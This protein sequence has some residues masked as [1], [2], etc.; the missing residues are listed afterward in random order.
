[1][2]ISF[3]GILHE[4]PQ[5][6]TVYLSKMPHTVFFTFLLLWQSFFDTIAGKHKSA[7]EAAA[8]RRTHMISIPYGN[9]H[10]KMDETGVVQILESRI[11]E[12]KGEKT[13]EEL[14]K[15][16]MEHPLG[17]PPLWELSRGKATAV[18]IISDHTRP[19]PSKKIIPFMLEQLRQGNPDIEITLLVATGCHRG[20]RREELIQKLGR[21]IVDGERI[22][23]HDC[24]DKEQLT[25]LGALPSG[26]RLVINRAAAETEL[27]VAE[28][29]IEPHFFA[30]FSGGRK[31]VLPGICSRMT[32]LGNHCAA[33]IDSPYA[34]T[35]N[36]EKNPIHRDMLAAAALAKLSYI[37][38]VVIDEDKKA[39]A[40][41]AGDPVQAHEAGC[42]FL[43]PYCQVRIQKKT[44]IV[45]TSN[46]G[47]PLD[48]NIY[49][50]VK[51][52]CTADAAVQEGGVIIICAECA[53]GTGGDDFY[54][55]LKN[56]TSIQ[57]LLQNIRST[58]MDETIPDQW[59]YQILA[60][61]LEK[62]RVIYVTESRWAQVIREMKMEYAPSLEA[63]L[64][65]ARS[66][67]GESEITVIPNGISVF[68]E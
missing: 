65:L 51:G 43:K 25:D 63:A 33:F 17:T 67:V 60:R 31:S 8:E 15:Q 30:G 26:S 24:D 45:V 18:V 11:G 14:V 16:A 56:C 27:L 21:E 10:L 50:T 58:P 9:T 54:Q 1:M 6:R 57:A 22:L 13:Q 39:A 3:L 59:Q 61:I 12:L 64:A 32:V 4:T 40:A 37:V 7:Q 48:Q 29:F 49:Q 53:D 36:L 23:I 42:A 2:S 19:V 55:A 35:G 52:L 46:G 47:A 34:R 20:T 28:G 5:K 41:F 62:K 44:P 66:L 38:N 68:L